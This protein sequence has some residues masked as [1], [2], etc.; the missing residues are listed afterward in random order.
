MFSY[1]GSLAIR[2]RF[3]V[4]AAALAVVVLGWA[5]GT[6]VTGDLVSGGFD[7]PG[8]DSFEVQNRLV[9]D[10]GLGEADVIALFGDETTSVNDPSFAAAAQSTLDEVAEQDGVVSVTSVYN[11]GGD[12]LVS[13]A[14]RPTFAG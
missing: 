7:V 3:G 6:G 10:L 5:Y 14:T 12:T 2:L 13:F 1:I 8:S 11:G 4:L 9:E